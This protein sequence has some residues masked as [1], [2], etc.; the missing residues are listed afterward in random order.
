MVVVRRFRQHDVV[1]DVVESLSG[2]RPLLLC[3]RCT[4]SRHR[5]GAG[6]RRALLYD[7]HTIIRSICA[8]GSLWTSCSASGWLSVALNFVIVVPYIQFF[9]SCTSQESEFVLVS[10][11][12]SVAFNFV[13]VVPYICL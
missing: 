11:W 10:C 13:M 5:G 1:Q 6:D 12:L 3:V 8:F 2:A 4:A 9:D 7:V